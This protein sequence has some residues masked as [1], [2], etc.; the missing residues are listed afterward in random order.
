MSQEKIDE[1]FKN[2]I[3]DFIRENIEENI[4]IILL[5]NELNKKLNNNNLTQR[6]RVKI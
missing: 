3:T 1:I 4:D 5:E 6:K 2:I